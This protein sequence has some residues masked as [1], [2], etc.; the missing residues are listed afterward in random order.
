MPN[1]FIS[2]RRTDSTGYAHWIYD[3]LQQEFS[4][5][6]VFIDVDKIDPGVDFRERL[7]QALSTADVALVLIGPSWLDARD[8]AGARRLEQ[9]EDF[10]R[11]E[12][13]EILRIGVPAI[14][15]LVDGAKMPTNELLPE[16]LRSLPPRQAFRFE[17]SGGPSMNNLIVDVRKAAQDK[18]QRSPST[19]PMER[20]TRLR[21]R[22]RYTA[23]TFC[24]ADMST[25]DQ[26]AAMMFYTN[27][28]GW[29][30]V[31]NRVTSD[32]YVSMMRLG[33]NNVCSISPASPLQ[34]M[35]G[36][37]ACWNS[38]IS[39]ESADLTVARAKELGATVVMPPIDVYR[40]GRVGVIQDP[41]GAM[42]VA[43]Q[44]N[45]HIGAS[46]V[47]TP[48]ALYWNE[49]V[50]PDVDGSVQF[51][52]KLFGWK[53]EP[54]EGM[55]MPYMTITNSDGDSNGGIRA[56][57]DTEP[58]YWLVYFGADDIDTSLKQVTELGGTTKWGPMQTRGAQIAFAH[59]PQGAPFALCAG[60]FDD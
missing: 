24:W 11:L 29:E 26:Q 42:V 18:V 5:N 57:N 44:P 15:V 53:V 21:E 33:G 45:D 30:A 25:V 41:Q 47:N 54:T 39:V 49:L 59:D 58:P 17:S 52:S 35:H 38:Y 23:G 7:K 36:V 19:R 3:R 34:S 46:L 6:K 43:W 22:T 28:F 37:P 8:E 10:V 27:L 1:V 16:D 51:Y 48:G 12:V 31:I 56:A 13:A 60:S 55:H 32:V 2:Y 9:P 50:S 40:A 14:P 4:N 20:A